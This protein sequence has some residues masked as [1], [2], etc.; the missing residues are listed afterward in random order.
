MDKNEEIIEKKKKGKETKILAANADLKKIPFFLK[1]GDIIGV[2]FESEN[3]TGE[4]DFQTEEDKILRDE[5]A[6]RKEQ[7]RIER[8]KEQAKQKTG[9]KGSKR[10]EGPGIYIRLEEDYPVESQVK[11]D[12]EEGQHSSNG[13]DKVSLD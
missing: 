3:I 1:D 11:I 8:E 10:Q 4:D 13:G 2:R 7:E 5:F 12:D 9:K 6:V